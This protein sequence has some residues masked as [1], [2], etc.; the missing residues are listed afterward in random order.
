MSS[1]LP[2]KETSREVVLEVAQHP[3]TMVSGDH[4]GVAAA[5]VYRI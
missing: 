1:L 5:D 2:M 3:S 4:R